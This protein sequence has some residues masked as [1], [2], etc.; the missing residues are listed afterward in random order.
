MGPTPS[1]PEM[2]TSLLQHSALV[3]IGLA[4]AVLACLW[5]AIAW[6]MALS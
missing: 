1:A 6:A 5:G 3:R 2:K 4:V